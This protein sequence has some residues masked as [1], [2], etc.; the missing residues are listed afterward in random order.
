[1]RR[2][3]NVFEPE[4]LRAVVADVIG[5][6]LQLEIGFAQRLIDRV[7]PELNLGKELHGHAVF[8]Q[9]VLLWIDQYLIQAREAGKQVGVPGMGH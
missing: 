7:E 6:T 3:A 8:A 4:G 1:M 9:H 5:S 2:F